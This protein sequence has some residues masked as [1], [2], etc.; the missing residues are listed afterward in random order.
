MFLPNH[1][2]DKQK[3]DLCELYSV[4]S[5]DGRFRYIS[6]NCSQYFGYEQE[7]LIGKDVRKF[8]HNEDSFLLESFFYNDHH[9]YPCTFRFQH[10]QGHYIWLEVMVDFIQNELKDYEREVVVK[11]KLLDSYNPPYSTNEIQHRFLTKQQST[12]P[13]VNFYK[14]A[15]TL[16]ES[17]PSPLFIS[18]NGTIRFA[19]A[20]LMELLKVRAKSEIIGESIYSFILP[21]YHH[22]VKTRIRLLYEGHSV[23][24][25][26]QE[27]MR[28]DGRIL[29][30]EC[31]PSIIEFQ[32]EKAEIV[33]MNDISSRKRVQKNLKQNQERYKRLIQNS[34]DTIAVIHN[35][36]WVFINDSGLKLFGVSDDTEM[37]GK[38]VFSFLEQ[39]SHQAMKKMLTNVKAGMKDVLLLKP[40]WKREGDNETIYTEMVCIPT[41]YFGEPAVQVILRD[42]TERKHAEEM[43]VQSEKLTIAGQLAAGI[44][45]EIRN[46]LTAIKGFLQLMQSEN[47]ENIQYFDIVFSELNRIELILSE[48]LMLAKPQEALI[49]RVGMNH[50]LSEVI[51]LL[52]TEANLNNVIIRKDF[53]QGNDHVY[54][55]SNQLK[56]VFINLVKNAIEAIPNGGSITI[57]T[58]RENQSFLIEFQDTGEG[59]P[60]SIL[61]KIGQPFITTKK[62]GNGLGL[63]MT[64]KI[65]ENHH[66]TIN[67]QSKEGEG[68][69]FTI[70][71]PIAEEENTR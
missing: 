61:Q 48:L 31:R 21:E 69:R 12:F 44:A 46:P 66:G 55:D 11:I 64:F 20:S 29:H 32:G 59:I 47:K 49:K 40:G 39:D 8:I 43:M 2:R 19:N 16:L 25:I 35:E 14:E 63:M 28:R 27:W 70:R 38:N 53:C 6:S 51:T 56:Q 3:T 22:V 45:H 15:I 65:I 37:I 42:L 34:I 4:L 18:I 7:E 9:L 13:K 17:L 71:L 58:K 57:Q 24:M 5:S 23:G 50:V 67:V 30:V 60:E 10:K 26:E 62:S 54:C 33:V 41:T 52:E 68:T 1:V 36:K